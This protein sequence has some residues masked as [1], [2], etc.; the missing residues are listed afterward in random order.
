MKGSLA[1][2]HAHLSD[3]AFENDLSEVLARAR[4]A[5]VATVVCVSESIADA[6]KNLALAKKHPMIVP[7]AGLYPSLLDFDLASA[8]EDLIRRERPHLGAIGEVGLDYWIVKDEVE[9]GVQRDI[10][11]RFIELS[12][13]LGLPLNIHSR[14]AGRHVI[15]L[16]LACN[17][18]KVQLHAFDGRAFYALRAV[19]A[20]YFFS[21]PPSVIHSTQK[22]KLVRQLPLE[23]LLLETDS[24]VLGPRRN[25]RNEP[26]HVIV[27]LEAIAE[28][29]E[30][31]VR[32]VQQAVSRNFEKLYGMTLPT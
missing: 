29:K 19:E 10:F 16:L 18:E 3:D 20:G 2:A 7:A 27:S 23:N 14:S 5:G 21:I 6:E 31:S 15:D 4:R 9:R 1:D 24:P 32:D 12:L 22:Q 30:L 11:K 26:A 13:E 8:M 17:A 25:E 28:I